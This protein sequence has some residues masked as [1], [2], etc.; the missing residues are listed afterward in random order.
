[1][2]AITG[3]MDE[4]I[5]DIRRIMAVES[6]DESG[7]ASIYQGRYKGKNLLL[8][9]TG[10]GKQNAQVA[11]RYLLSRQKV[12]A[13][14]STGFAGALTPTL[15]VGDIVVYSSVICADSLSTDHYAADTRLLS[16]ARECKAVEFRSG[17]GIT[18]LNLAA[19]VWEKRKLNETTSAEVVDM[20]SYWI[21][22]VADEY[23][24]PLVIIRSVSDALVD[25]LPEL[26]TWRRREVIPYLLAHPGQGLILYRAV[27]RARK[28]ISA[29]AG[30]MIEKAG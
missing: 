15:K 28:N 9:R 19:N 20:E 16:I 13:I 30:Y 6:K 4:E 21:A 7:E 25:S 27:L 2:L 1:M 18:G 22:R 12:T 24:I 10:V 11:L 29:F 26:S 3:A 5:K 17:L 14:I 23:R 8:V